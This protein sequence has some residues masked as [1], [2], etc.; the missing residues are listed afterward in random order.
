VW[1]A[2]A[3]TTR[4]IKIVDGFFARIAHSIVRERFKSPLSS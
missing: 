1:P 3:S 2:I 4:D